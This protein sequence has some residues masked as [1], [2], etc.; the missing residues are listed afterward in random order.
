MQA[1]NVHAYVHVSLSKTYKGKLRQTPRLGSALPPWVG[2]AVQAGAW[3]RVDKERAAGAR[4]SDR[5]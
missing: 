3:S 4:T 5:R 1:H 2:E